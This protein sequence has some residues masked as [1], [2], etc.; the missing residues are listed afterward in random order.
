MRLRTVAAVAWAASGSALLAPPCAQ[1]ARA[2]AASRFDIPAQPLGQALNQLAL[3]SNREI[4]FSPR[5]TAGRRGPPVRGVFSAEDALTKL[6]AGSGLTVRLE[7][8]SFLIQPAP[9]AP[10]APHP[11]KTAPDAA[12]D[13]DDPLEAVVVT[14]LRRDSEMQKTPVSMT[15]LTGGTLSRLGMVD[16]ERAAPLLPGLK[17][18]STSFGRRL[19]L[20]GVY[21]AGEATTGLYYDETPMT[22]PVGTTADPGVMTPELAL[23]DVDRIELLRGPQGTLYGSGSMGGA[24]RVLFRRPDLDDANGF[25]SAS[26]TSLRHGGQAG[27]IT[28]A[29][30]PV[31][32]SGVLAARLTVYDLDTPGVVDNVRLGLSDVDSTAV[33]GARL[34]LQ[35]RPDQ[36]LSVLLSATTQTTHRDDISAW[37]DIAGPWRTRHAAR[38]P[39]DGRIDLAS[40]SLHWRGE[41][42]DVT[43]TASWYRWRLTRRSDYSG[44]LL[45]ER[46]SASGCA[47]YYALGGACDPGQMQGYASYVDSLYPAI[48]NQPARLT[49]SI[50]EVR[51]SSVRD[52]PLGWTVGVYNEV[53][54]DHIDSQV[55]HVDP[56][57]GAP[58][59][60][61]VLI[62]RRSIDNH[63]GQS[64]VFGELSYDPAPETRVTLGARRF[65][66]VKRDRGEVQVPN[67]V[68]G[69]WADYVIDA[70]TPEQG[71]SLKALA[72]RQ[73]TA[74]VLGYV[75]VSQGFRPGGV[76]VVPGLADTLAPY[77]SDRLTN[78]EAGLKSQSA[79]HRFTANLAV[80]QIDWRDMQY[81]AQ[82]Q[83]RAFSFL[84]NIG[85]SRIRGMEAEFAARSLWGWDAVASATF[86]DARLTADQI[87][88]T[89]IGLGLEGDRLPVVPRFATAGS[90]ERRWSLGNGL[91]GRLR[92]DA[93]YTG[94][95]R[96]AFNPGNADYL[97]MGGYA[98]FGAS[99][100][101][102]HASW[103]GE[104][105]IDN[106]L[107]RAGRASAQRNTSGPVDYYGI[108]PRSVRLTLER[109]F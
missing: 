32:V 68:S 103:R 37:H 2:E 55:P 9:V 90:L 12:S 104:L 53:R 77:R 82:T 62:G 105:A 23:V 70:R 30:N 25:V 81:S 21:G 101:V 91:E 31:I 83:N 58:Q 98:T 1:A 24:L 69:T 86:T 3:Q 109:G 79:D 7:G 29:V 65:S 17:L 8:R 11:A 102:E 87:T 36:R 6:L 67:V 88:N 19:V 39:F 75:Q 34:G 100:G 108:A 92:L 61:A 5:L 72:S 89:A 26:A 42:V 13:S 94:T 52:S 28:A 107:D 73:I 96:S 41:A 59:Q 15:V 57:T 43:A 45:G 46:D 97:K 35:W 27:G 93:A 20:R 76:N 80:Y 49:S 66:Y 50:Q 14:A 56:L 16:L 47:R 54:D 71:W 95:S 60:P 99:F 18:V 10:S 48:L 78:Y 63:L 44:V 38:A 22:G 106:L 84:T 74:D 64:A 51:A 4:L 33:K 85:A 40:A